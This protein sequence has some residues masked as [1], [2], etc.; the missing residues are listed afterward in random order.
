MP[1][2]A[3]EGVMLRS[4]AL[5]LL[6]SA[7][8]AATASA[9]DT[10]VTF[11][12]CSY[13]PSSVR[14]VPHDTLT[15]APEAGNDFD[16]S[17]PKASNH[18]PLHFT[19][20]TIGD[21]TI[22]SAPATRPFD[23]SGV[24]MWYCGN[25]GTYDGTN[26]GGMSGRVVVT[27]NKLPVADFTASATTVASG[28]DVTFDGSPSHDPDGNI[29]AYA[30]DLDG[31]GQPDPGQTAEQ[32]SAVFANSGTTPRNVTVR[33]T[34]TDDNGDNVGPESASKSMVIIVA[35][36]P[37]AGGGYPPA[38]SGGGD[39][40][41]TT[42]AA[43]PVV[44][45]TIA[46]SLTV[47]KVLRVPFTTN[48][49]TSVTATLKVG[50]K[51]AKATKDFATTGKHTLTIKL[52]KALRRALRKRRSVTLTLA[53]TDDAGNGTTVKRTLKLRARQ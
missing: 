49:S 23:T 2:V 11:R 46:K 38:T 36:E 47:G 34:V 52:S 40:A 42:D 48:E 27:A 5:A 33:L 16:G 53:A 25:H 7:V 10:Q 9:A 43:A 19:A 13:S 20:A 14:I 15:F 3:Y 41:Q 21:Q 50:N 18:H 37:G 17:V 39:G 28:T 35:P 6:A 22:G 51:T 24:F 29:T 32:T 1:G 8:F 31:N 44:Q 26:V 30:W 12:C 4:C 45:L